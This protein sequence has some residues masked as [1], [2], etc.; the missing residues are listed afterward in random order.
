MHFIA[1]NHYAIPPDE[2]ETTPIVDDLP[3]VPYQHGSG[4]ELKRMLPWLD[5]NNNS[6]TALIESLNDSEP[7]VIRDNVETFVDQLLFI[8]FAKGLSPETFSRTV[9]KSLVL[10]AARRFERKFPD[11]VPN[12]NEDSNEVDR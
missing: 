6:S 10:T 11:G 12:S 1:I 5:L 9:A 8:A 2:R 7:F 3:V 4:T